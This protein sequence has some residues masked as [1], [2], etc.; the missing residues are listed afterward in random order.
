M[1]NMDN[2][3]AHTFHIPVMGTGFTIDTPLRI[4]KYGIS[5]V[6]S[7]VD[8]LLIEQMRKLHS[9]MAGEPYEEIA[10]HEED[11]RARR[12]TAYLNLIDRL[13]GDQVRAVQTSPFEKDSHITNYFQMLPDT[14][15]KQTYN[16]M[17]KTDDPVAKA[18]LQEELRRRVVPGS[19]DVNIMTKLDHDQ[20]IKGEKQ[21]QQ[22]SDALSALR[23]YAN[24]TLSSSVIFSAGINPRLYSYIAQFEDF[25]PDENGALR[26]KIV[27]KV[28]DYRSALVQS[29][30]LAKRGLWVSEYR[31]ESGLNCGGH[32][33]ATKGHL[34]GAILEEFKRKKREVIEKLHTIY[35][36]ALSNRNRNESRLPHKIRLTVQGGIGTADED[37][38]LQ[39]YY[40][41]DGTGWGTP[42]LLVPE[43]INID[44]EHLKKLS[45]AKEQDVYLSD[46]SPLGIPFWNLRTS[47]SEENRR[48]LIQEGKPGSTC[49]KGHAMINKELTKI[50]ICIASRA[51]QKLKLQQLQMENLSEKLLSLVK[52]NILVKSCLCHDLAGNATLKN[53]IDPDAKPAV[54][55]G[56]NILNFS[57][58]A[59]L[60]EMVGHIYGRLSLLTNNNRPH[61]FIRELGLYVDYF[62]NEYEKLSSGLLTNTPK[63]FREFKENLLNGIEY[64]R[65]IAEELV[66]EQ[67]ERFLSD[68]K[69]LLHEFELISSATPVEVCV[70]SGT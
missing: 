69:D 56:P 34:L 3:S 48:R 66:E 33:F 47:A 59:T 68:L 23:G 2:Q 15:L 42:F 63:Y 49:P 53:N 18:G 50:P 28:S 14:P 31:I 36:K 41:V 39:K 22:F 19:I 44:K 35:D 62:R 10:K 7:L 16:H 9:E 61:M 57:K 64:Y 27:L 40:E 25:F 17:L 6:I 1:K 58:I 52:E 60:E 37:Q 51:Y 12:I 38:F 21:P 24:S 29:K 4:A 32:T 45:G 43:A 55:T 8:D 65:R 30:F 46:C 5:S 13:V 70:E 26:K 54:T 11:S 20:Y 67:R